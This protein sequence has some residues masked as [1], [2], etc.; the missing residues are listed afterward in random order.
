M[1]FFTKQN[2]FCINLDRRPDRL[3][4]V[5]REF[6]KIG[7][8]FTRFSAIDGNEVTLPATCKIGSGHYGCFLSHIAIWKKAIEN[9]LPVIAIFED[10]VS[11]AIDFNERYFLFINELPVSW[12]MVNLGPYGEG[13]RPIGQFYSQLMT[14]TWG[15]HAYLIKQQSIQK[16]LN[17]LGNFFCEE[18]VDNFLFKYSREVLNMSILPL[19]NV[20]LSNRK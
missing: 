6:E 18:A 14:F 12:D 2:T 9:N 15:T 13:A 19:E 3:K 1:F 4:L 8:E 5:V 7:G 10:D 20:V 16:L 11:F 17:N